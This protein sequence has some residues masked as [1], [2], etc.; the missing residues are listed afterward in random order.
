MSE[1][2]DPQIDLIRENLQPGESLC[3][4]GSEP[5]AR[6]RL[7]R[8]GRMVVYA[9]VLVLAGSLAALLLLQ[10]T[11]FLRASAWPA[12]LLAVL[13]LL[14]AGAGA[15][16][17]KEAFYP[18]K[19]GPDAYAITDRRA[20]VVTS[21][22]QPVCRSYPADAVAKM[23]V[24]RNPGGSGDILFERGP[25]WGSDPAG[26]AT[27][28]LQRIGFFG[29]ASVDEVYLLLEQLATPDRVLVKRN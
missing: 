4:A 28:H 1:R 14:A 18:V 3:W 9:L 25:R 29:L 2:V 24:R 17:V 11:D 27:W 10:Y 7:H 8:F 20:L 23:E 6:Y 13:L 16:L 26:R 15:V 5:D 12:L 19:C 21:G 22:R